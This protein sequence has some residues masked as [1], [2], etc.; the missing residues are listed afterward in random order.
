MSGAGSASEALVTIGRVVKPHGI[1]GEVVVELLSEVPDRFAAGRSVRVG[2]VS[3]TIVS[4]RPHQ[5]RMLVAFDGVDDR[6]AA[7]RLRGRAVEAEPV[8]LGES[9][10]YYVH[11]LVGMAVIDEDGRELGR[12]TAAIELPTAAG[13]DLLEIRRADG[14]T[15]LLP[16]VDDYVVVEEGAGGR[17]Q[18]RLVDPPVGLVDDQGGDEVPPGD[19]DEVRG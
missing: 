7:E 17:E 10:T 19:Q 2:A 3:T 18:L 14:S 6:S 11:E 13:Y 16:A 12:V 9:D 15:W 1:R 5:G 4:S 8:D